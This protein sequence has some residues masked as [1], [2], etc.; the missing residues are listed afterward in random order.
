M[1]SNGK[2]DLKEASHHP[3]HGPQETK[4]LPNPYQTVSQLI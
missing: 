1:G 3:H 2:T 4:Q